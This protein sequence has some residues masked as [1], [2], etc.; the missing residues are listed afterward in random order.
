LK[1]CFTT[2]I[3]KMNNNRKIP[4]AIGILIITSIVAGILSSV[5]ALEKPDFL[6][7]LA[8]KNGQVLIAVFFQSIMA[9]AYT[10][11]AALFYPIVKKSSNNAA[12]GYFSFRIIGA[13]FLY[14]GIVTLLS[15]LFLSNSYISAGQP[16]AAYYQ[17]VSELIRLLRDWL[18][19]AGL[20]LPWSMGGLI[21]YHS[22]YKTEFLPK[23]LSIWGIAASSLTIII[24]FLFILDFVKVASVMYFAFNIPTAFFEM[25]LA[26][27]LLVKGF[28]FD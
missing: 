17:T 25:T 21:L 3:V 10:L 26:V 2:K 22:L 12:I 23:W 7:T 20:I 4:T 11:I 19:H 1:I 28:N 8:S 15:L 24:T 6:T 5:P 16:E 14:I 27:Y 18:N 13:G 9:I